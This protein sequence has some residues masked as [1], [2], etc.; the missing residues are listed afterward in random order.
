[1]GGPPYT[2][3][4]EAVLPER[5]VFS[6]LI[7]LSSVHDREVKLKHRVFKDAQEQI[8]ELYE[9]IPET[10]RKAKTVHGITSYLTHNACEFFCNLFVIYKTR[11]TM[12]LFQ[13]FHELGG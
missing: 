10:E 3:F 6:I 2:G 1:M 8:C 12:F 4:T 11:V 7:P 5:R 13:L 9:R